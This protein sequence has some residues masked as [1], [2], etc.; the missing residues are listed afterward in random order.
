MVWTVMAMA[1]S[2]LAAATACGHSSDS[3][4][5]PALTRSRNRLVVVGDGVVL[6][7]G[8]RLAW[9]S[10]DRD[11]SLA[12]NDADRHCRGLVRGERGNWRLP[13]IGELQA[14]YDRHTDQPCGDTRCHLDPAIR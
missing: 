6:D 3:S 9:T 7:P 13:E 4:G 5:A 11:Q 1:A 2:L 12:W 14:L 8:T 10:R